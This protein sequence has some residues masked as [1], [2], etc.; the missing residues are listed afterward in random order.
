MV[1][2]KDVTR[3]DARDAD[4]DLYAA[5]SRARH[6]RLVVVGADGG[7]AGYVHQLDVLGG[8]P[9]EPVLEHLREV[10]ALA[11]GI[12]VDRALARLRAS[13]QRLAIVG[14]PGRPLGIVTLKDLLEEISGDLAGW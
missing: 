8:G 4:A 14:D 12:A 1:P 11:P 7:V 13:G 6:T 5:V 3:L 9:G 10:G 2:W